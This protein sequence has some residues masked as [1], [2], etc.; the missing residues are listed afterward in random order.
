M[1]AK[2]IVLVLWASLDLRRAWDVAF[3]SPRDP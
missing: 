1:T 2:T 3:G